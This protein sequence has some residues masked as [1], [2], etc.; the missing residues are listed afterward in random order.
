MHAAAPLDHRSLTVVLMSAE[1]WSPCCFIPNFNEALA[2]NRASMEVSLAHRDELL[3][4]STNLQMLLLLH[5]TMDMLWRPRL[6]QPES[7]INPRA[8]YTMTMDFITLLTQHIFINPVTPVQKVRWYF[9]QFQFVLM[10]LWATRVCS[11]NFWGALIWSIFTLY[12]GQPSVSSWA[13][14]SFPIL[15]SF[16]QALNVRW[17]YKVIWLFII[18]V[19]GSSLVSAPAL[20]FGTETVDQTAKSCLCAHSDQQ[21]TA[22]VAQLWDIMTHVVVG[23]W[24]QSVMDHINTWFWLSPVLLIVLKNIWFG[25]HFTQAVPV[26]CQ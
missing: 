10:E 5:L 23:P 25:L 6:V 16:C 14:D 11:V 19:H 7:N 1:P 22:V 26:I 17:S 3:K 15:L 2:C 24:T 13:I 20:Y 9:G 12:A 8:T 4:E 18:L 21:V